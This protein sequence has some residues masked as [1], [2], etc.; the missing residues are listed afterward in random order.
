QIVSYLDEFSSNVKKLKQNY[1]TQIKNLQELKKSL[2]D[3]AFQGR[4]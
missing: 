4:L 3:K 1:Q 2:L